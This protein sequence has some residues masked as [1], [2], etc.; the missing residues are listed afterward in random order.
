MI[1]TVMSWEYLRNLMALYIYIYFIAFIGPG[2][3]TK[4]ELCHTGKCAASTISRWC[5]F[6]QQCASKIPLN[7]SIS[8]SCRIG[9]HPNSR[10]RMQ[11]LKRCWLLCWISR[12]KY[13]GMGL[14]QNATLI[15]W[16]VDRP[17]CIY[18]YVIILDCIYIYTHARIYLARL[19]AMIV[20]GP[21]VEVWKHTLSQDCRPLSL[22]ML[23]CCLM[24]LLS[25]LSL[26]SLLL[27]LLLLLLLVLL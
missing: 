14:V 5:M 25:L 22:F 8:L 2:K 3:G 15:A 20:M 7:I 21:N 26:L 4:T 27:L 10:G 16:P 9:F 24:L 6:F 12:C 18:I 19:L 17:I 1:F 23:F 11:R 13:L